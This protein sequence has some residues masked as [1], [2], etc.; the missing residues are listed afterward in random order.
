[1]DLCLY[2]PGTQ[3]RRLLI[4]RA[5]ETCAK[6]CLENPDALHIS[7][8]VEWLTRVIN[9]VADMSDDTN[10]GLPHLRKGK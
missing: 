1:V 7:T 3:K 6:E 4:S 8:F 5:G 2:E 10:L 9:G